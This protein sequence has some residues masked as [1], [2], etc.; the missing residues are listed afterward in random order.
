MRFGI[1]NMWTDGSFE[2]E[3]HSKLMSR[4][5]R[6]LEQGTIRYPDG[7]AAS[8]LEFD[9]DP[10]LYMEFRMLNGDFEPMENPQEPFK[11][12]RI[13]ILTKVTDYWEEES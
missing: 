4:G 5:A 11:S 1:I 7:S 13:P 6:F 2:R 3:V 8:Y 12:K 10:R 9:V